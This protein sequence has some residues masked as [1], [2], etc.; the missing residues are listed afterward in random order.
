[1]QRTTIIMGV[2]FLILASRIS[3]GCYLCSK[4]GVYRIKRNLR[5]FGTTTAPSNSVGRPR[6]ITPEI[7]D[8]LC[9]H[10]LD[11]PGFYHHEM[12][13]LVWNHF[14]VHVTVSSVR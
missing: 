13:D 9:E 3:Q 1:M 12:V 11:N 14:H 6:S 8:T 10:L 7:Q 4:R 5:L 2:P